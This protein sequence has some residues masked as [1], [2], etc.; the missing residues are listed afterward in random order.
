M[1]FSYARAIIV[2]VPAAFLSLW[3]SSHTIMSSLGVRLIFAE[4]L[5]NICTEVR[6]G[7]GLE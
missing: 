5:R 1:K 7:L 4:Y 6:V 3:P 2:L